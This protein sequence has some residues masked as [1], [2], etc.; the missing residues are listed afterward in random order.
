MLRIVEYWSISFDVWGTGDVYGHSSW[1]DVRHSPNKGFLGEDDG[2]VSGQPLH[3]VVS[4]P[5]ALLPEGARQ[6]PCPQSESH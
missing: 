6:R 2:I 4:I 5:R 1:S 3:R